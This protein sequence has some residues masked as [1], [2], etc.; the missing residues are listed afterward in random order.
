MSQVFAIPEVS[1]TSIDTKDPQKLSVITRDAQ[2]G[3]LYCHAF[4][5]SD[6]SAAPIPK[7]IGV[8]FQRVTTLMQTADRERLKELGLL[9]ASKGTSGAIGVFDVKHIAT[10]PTKGSKGNDTCQAALEDAL[11][12]GKTREPFLLVVSEDGIRAIDGLT[13]EVGIFLCPL[14]RHS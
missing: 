9:V 8:A 11:K 7:T 6:G 10:S 5:I 2:F 13:S 12:L 4:S 14:C 1:F 3:L